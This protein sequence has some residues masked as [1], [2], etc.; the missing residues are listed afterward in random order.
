MSRWAHSTSPTNWERKAAI[1]KHII[2]SHGEGISVRS[3]EGKGTTF[4]FT[5]RRAK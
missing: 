2:E 5:L 3:E 4:S 1:V